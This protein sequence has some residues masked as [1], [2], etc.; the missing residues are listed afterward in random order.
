[1]FPPSAQLQGNLCLWNH[2][3]PHQW[4]HQSYHTL[5][6]QVFF[7]SFSQFFSQLSTAKQQWDSGSEP[8]SQARRFASLSQSQLWVGESLNS[9][10][11]GHSY[12]SV[13]PLAHQPYQI[14]L[15][16]GENQSQTVHPTNTELLGGIDL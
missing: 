2:P 11:L 15:F 5:R 3:S 6:V 16:S 14:P 7:S 10:V 13:F 1:M 9:S 8:L 4:T 12:L